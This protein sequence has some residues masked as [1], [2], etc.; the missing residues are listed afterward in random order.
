[1]ITSIAECMILVSVLILAV[2]IIHV[3]RKMI[4]GDE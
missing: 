3:V 4:G 2:C 1:M